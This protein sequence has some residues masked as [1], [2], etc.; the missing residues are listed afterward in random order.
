MVVVSFCLVLLCA[1]L[2]CFFSLLIM[3]KNMCVCWGESGKRWGRGKCG[4]NIMYEKIMKNK[5][6]MV[7]KQI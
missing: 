7:G 4:Q 6:H 3:I 2:F 5:M 1:I